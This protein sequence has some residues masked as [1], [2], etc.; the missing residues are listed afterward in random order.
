VGEVN[1]ALSL[2]MQLSGLMTRGSSVD[3]T[4]LA[5]DFRQLP[6]IQALKRRR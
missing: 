6:A 3:P 2:R 5:H 1:R 4:A